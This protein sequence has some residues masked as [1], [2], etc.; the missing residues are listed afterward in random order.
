M[1][2]GLGLDVLLESHAPPTFRVLRDGQPLPGFAVEFRTERSRL[3]IWRRTDAEGRVVF[4]PP[5]DGAWVLRGIDLRLSDRVPD[6]FDSRFVT[7]AFEVK[8]QN[9]INASP[10][11]RST[12]QPPATSTISDEPPT[13]TARP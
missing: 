3:G 9:G 13:N 11:A 10:N 5:L 7:L 6:T 12:N 4:A 2:S 1:P 8:N